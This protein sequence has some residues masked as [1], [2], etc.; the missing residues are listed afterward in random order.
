MGRFKKLLANPQLNGWGFFTGVI[1]LLFAFYTYWVSQSFP[2]LLAEVHPARTILVSPEG[3]QDLTIFANGKQI[4]GPVTSV[5][6]AIWNAGTKPI[7]AEDVLEK[8]RIR[9]NKTTP[10]I[11]VR[12]LKMTRDVT[13]VSA[14]ISRMTEGI[15]GI[16]FKIL[17][18]SDA[19]L[20]QLTYEG[21]EKIEFIGSGIIVGQSKFELLKFTKN[22]S[23]EEKP[24]YNNSKYN[25]TI[26]IALI[27]VGCFFLFKAAPLLYR[28]I[29]QTIIEL[30]LNKGILYKTKIIVNFLIELITIIIFIYMIFNVLD[31]FNLNI[32]P[33]LTEQSAVD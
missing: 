1:G 7:R 8:I 16:N 28:D 2:N 6:I 27:L 19:V 18:S 30:K 13:G 32:S 11:S 5:Q 33:F 24:N 26:F 21:D 3:A 9:T 22:P 31:D 17:E 15:I 25:K 20:L 10:I 23:L 4:K 12:I 14:D 29:N